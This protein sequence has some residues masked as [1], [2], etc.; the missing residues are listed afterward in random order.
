MKYLFIFLITISVLSC[1]KEDECS[2][3]SSTTDLDPCLSGFLFDKGS[4]WV[5]QDTNTF[6]LDSTY[7]ENWNNEFES[8]KSGPGSCAHFFN[9]DLVNFSYYSTRRDSFSRTLY[10]SYIN[11]TASSGYDDR[12]YACNEIVPLDSIVL[13]NS[14]VYNV[15]KI[16]TL[17]SL[18][19][20]FYKSGVGV[21]RRVEYNPPIDTLTYDLIDYQVSLFQLPQ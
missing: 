6:L 7:V 16:S 10:G 4:F 5:Y 18:I 1:S 19:T 21:I 12:I 11:I 14:T 13:L 17:D 15:V 3:S 2:S 20:L 8:R 9:R